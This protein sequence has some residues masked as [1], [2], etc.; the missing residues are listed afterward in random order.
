MAVTSRILLALFA[1]MFFAAPSMAA[2]NYQGIGAGIGMGFS[3]LGIGVGLGLIG[4]AALSGIARQP[5]QAGKIQG[6]MFILAG[7]VEGAGI[8]SLVL[9]LLIG[10]KIMGG[11]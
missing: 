10:A 4:F 8:L 6:A 3:V 7:L 11:N 2:E 1:V 9:C 5:E